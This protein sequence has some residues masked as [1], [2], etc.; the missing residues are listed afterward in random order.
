MHFIFCSLIA[1]CFSLPI[2]WKFYYLL[3]AFAFSCSSSLVPSTLGIS[4]SKISNVSTS[5]LRLRVA[6]D[7]VLMFR[8]CQ[9]IFLRHLRRFL[10][11]SCVLLSFVRYLFV[12]H[13]FKSCYYVFCCSRFP[14]PYALCPA[15][16][17][18]PTSRFCRRVLLKEFRSSWT[19][20]RLKHDMKQRERMNR[21]CFRACVCMWERD[22]GE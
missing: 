3:R 16:H 17:L 10:Y 9:I 15:L 14:C 22:K 13:L 7:V 20:G 4:K 8:V 2:S 18:G 1:L 5:S 19:L 6:C 12:S 11:L 21:I